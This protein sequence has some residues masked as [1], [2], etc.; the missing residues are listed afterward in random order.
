MQLLGCLLLFIQTCCIVYSQMFCISRCFQMAFIKLSLK[1]ICIFLTVKH[2]LMGETRSG[3]LQASV[4]REV[5]TNF[6]SPHKARS[7][8]LSCHSAVRYL[9]TIHS[10]N[11][12]SY[13][14]TMMGSKNCWCVSF[15]W[16]SLRHFVIV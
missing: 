15:A 2:V 11:I 10:I 8:S 14:R 4:L 3:I 9:I 6:W 12:P 5:F 7:K 13:I 1:P 16:L